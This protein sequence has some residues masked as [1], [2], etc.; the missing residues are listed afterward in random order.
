MKKGLII[1]IILFLG[2]IIVCY[3]GSKIEPGGEEKMN[4][5]K[6]NIEING[7]NYTAT[8]ENNETTRKLIEELPLEIVMDE[9]NGNEKYYY[10]STTLP[11][12]AQNVTNIEAGDIMLYGDRC[13]VIFYE[14]FKTS[15][16]YTRIGK[17]DNPSSLKED[18]GAKSIEVL[19]KK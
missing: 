14:S 7:K 3:I 15:Y 16:S 5:N 18:V 1:L 2:L 11:T 13:L 10:L 6:I 4:T 9:L 8:L 19:I 12:N 17:I